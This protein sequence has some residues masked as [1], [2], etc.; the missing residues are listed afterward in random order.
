MKKIFLISAVTFFIQVNLEAQINYTPTGLWKSAN[1]T[2]TI[3]MYFKPGQIIINPTTTYNILL[4]FHKYKKNGVLIE[5]SLQDTSSSYI[6]NKYTM[7]SFIYNPLD[8]RNDGYLK[9]LTLNNKRYI[10]LKKINL[11]TIEVSLTY[12]QGVRNNRPYGFTLPRHF[13]LTKL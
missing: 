11:T 4:G 3:I 13:T 8:A 5:S 12:I 10:I 2:D 7:T 1:A 9:D 6:E